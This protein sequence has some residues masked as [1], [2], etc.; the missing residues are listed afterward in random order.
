VIVRSV[1]IGGMVD[2][3]CLNFLFIVWQREII[4]LPQVHN[5]VVLRIEYAKIE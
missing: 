5:I 1:D 3:H 4:L 2:H